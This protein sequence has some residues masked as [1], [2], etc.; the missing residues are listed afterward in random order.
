[1][2]V[3]FNDVDWLSTGCF[4]LSV[5]LV[6]IGRIVTAILVFRFRN[7]AKQL[8]KQGL[9]KKSVEA[10]VRG[11]RR[12]R[13]ACAC[14]ACCEIIRRT[15]AQTLHTPTLSTSASFISRWVDSPTNVK[16]YYQRV[17]KR[18]HISTYYLST[19]TQVRLKKEGEVLRG[20]RKRWA[21]WLPGNHFTLLDGDWLF[22]VFQVRWIFPRTLFEW[23]L[24]WWFHFVLRASVPV[25]I[26]RQNEMCMWSC[27][28]YP[29]TLKTQP[30]CVRFS[31][32]V[33]MCTTSFAHIMLK[34]LLSWKK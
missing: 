23:I 15:V 2:L 6:H 3:S 4:C 29:R 19:Q 27:F 20:K 28:L 8:F 9:L 5:V 16:D 34:Y 12:V 32:H 21:S 33:C 7:F 22:S 26:Q 11:V 1:M 18:S 13:S 25:A 30:R 17:Y 10:V 14:W 31:L 24:M